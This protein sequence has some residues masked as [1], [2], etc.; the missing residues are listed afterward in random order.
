MALEL[1]PGEEV[2]LRRLREELVEG[3]YLLDGYDGE[4][5][6]GGVGRGAA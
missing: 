6:R 3:G 2:L 4:D 5:L 1:D